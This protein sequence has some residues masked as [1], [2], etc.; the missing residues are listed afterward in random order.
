MKTNTQGLPAWSKG[1]IAVAVTGGVVLLGFQLYKVLKKVLDKGKDD[2]PKE[3]V[4]SAIQDYNSAASQGSKLSFPQSVYA[5]S[6]EA[7]VKHL[8][9]CETLG[10][11]LAAIGEVI[12]AVKKP[13]DWYYLIKV[14]DQKDVADCGT[15]GFAKTRYSL[16]GLLKEQLDTFAVITPYPATNLGGYVVPSGYYSDSIEILQKYLKGVGVTL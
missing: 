15:F 2:T 6:A 12:K 14:F 9:G 3:S 13:I 5:G 16:Q 8:D 10:S 4:N 7:I 11:E 1:V